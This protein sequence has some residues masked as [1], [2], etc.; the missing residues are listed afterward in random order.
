MV[1]LFLSAASIAAEKSADAKGDADWPVERRYRIGVD[2]ALEGSAAAHQPVCVEAAFGKLL[3]DKG[4]GSDFDPASV[5][6]TLADDSSAQTAIPHLMDEAF[7][8]SDSGEV[9]WDV[10]DSA[11][12]RFFIYFDTVDHGP[13]DRQ[14]YISLVGAGD[15]FRYN[16]PGGR[17]PIHTMMISPPIAADF[18]GDGRFDVLA[19]M[20]YGSTWRQPWFTVWY[21]RNIG[22]NE[23]PLFADRVILYADGNP[24]PNGYS[25]I[26][27]IDWD[28]DGKL[29]LVARDSVYQNTGKLTPGGTPILTKL[30]DLPESMGQGFIGLA[31][32][33]GDG[34]SDAFRV[35]YRCHY[36]YEGPPRRNIVTFSMQRIAN[37]AA[38]GKP[39]VFGKTEAVLLDG[40]ETL[41]GLHP[42]AFFDV[43]ADGDLDVVGI[44][45]PLTRNPE[46]S[47]F[48]WWPNNAKKGRPPKYGAHRE[49]PN[50]GTNLGT[51]EIFGCS[52]PAF[53]GLLV[54]QGH[55][56]WFFQRVD[57]QD[58]AKTVTPDAAKRSLL[59]QKYLDGTYTFVDR[60]LLM[61]LN[62]RCAVDGFTGVDVKDW[63]GDGDWDI[64]GGDEL[65]QAWLIENIGNNE[66]PVFAHARRL[67]AGGSP[68]RIT[69]WRYIPDGNPEWSLGQVKLRYVDW[70]GDGDCDL[71][72]GNTTH[73]VLFHEN[74]G[75]R[76]YPQ[77][78]ASRFVEVE[79]VQ[80][81]F[82]LRSSIAVVDFNGDGLLDLSKSDAAGSPCIFLRY[83]DNGELKLRPGKP[84][85]GA[86]AKFSVD[87]EEICDWDGDGDW[88]LL[89]NQGEW[90]KSGPVICENIG[91]N[92][93]PVFKEPVPLACWGTRIILSAHE[94]TMAAV[95]WY[96][97]GKPDLVC[98]GEIGWFYFF[99]RPALDD[100]HPPKATLAKEIEV[101]EGPDK[102]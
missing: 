57:F 88:D 35:I 82:A 25:G 32:H 15:N 56:I 17:D 23:K 8:R 62:S 76:K 89:G 70:D 87:V 83:R 5:V 12:H 11:K 69:R 51:A 72:A 45:R 46:H 14:D 80:A 64:F 6:V 13:Y 18:D 16:R 101:R 44:D 34:V 96:G 99:R 21:W 27:V 81:P 41:E 59:D 86:N 102:K 77:F 53:N 31:D 4:I 43:D 78:A 7:K 39:P 79:G 30:A 58:V 67:E 40:K 93:E 48:C 97:T 91:S 52:D 24:I 20:C 42:S 55:R 10:V 90:S 74:V 33:D 38:A 22:S 75:S 94:K 98:G 65:G 36:I 66:Q 100:P 85:F 84:L 29:D 68:M 9:S 26:G 50:S 37:T 2:F 71:L 61:Q 92:A 19:S 1:L 54:G 49:L 47:R 28:G 73:R 60:G 95:D 3:K 63:E